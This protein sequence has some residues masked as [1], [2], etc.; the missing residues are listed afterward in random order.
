MGDDIPDGFFIEPSHPLTIIRDLRAAKDAFAFYDQTMCE[1]L[2]PRRPDLL[3]HVRQQ[4][5]CN[6]RELT[7]TLSHN[8]KNLPQ[9]VDI[10]QSTGLLVLDGRKLTASCDELQAKVS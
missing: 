10:L 5:A 9:N 4:G 6:V 2:S 8:Y 7:Q 3:C 1:E